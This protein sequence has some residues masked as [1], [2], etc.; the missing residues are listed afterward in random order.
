MTFVT[1]VLGSLLR[2]VVVTAFVLAISRQWS[3]RLNL[4]DA[5]WR[6]LTWAFILAPG[7]VPELLLGY[8]YAPWVIGKPRLAEIVCTLLLGLRLLPVGVIAWQLTPPS[9]LSRSA[10]HVRRMTP[11]D[12]RQMI[13][14]FRCWWVGP[15]RSTIPAAAL[16]GLLAF[17]EFELAALLK[18]VSWTNWLFV[19]QQMGQ[20]FAG[21]VRAATV[22]AVLQI[23]VIG[24]A[25]M[26]L[27]PKYG[28]TASTASHVEFCVPLALPVSSFLSGDR[29]GNAEDTGRASG[30]Q[31]LKHL[32]RWFLCGLISAWL[33][34]ILA[35]AF[36]VIV[37]LSSLTW[38]LPAGIVQLAGQA[39]RWQG[40]L[41][42]L[43]GN[44]AVSVTAACAAWTLAAGVP[45]VIDRGR[46]RGWALLVGIAC[47][48]GLSGSLVLSLGMLT[49]FQRSLSG[50]YDTPVMWVLASILFLLPRAVL[51]RLWLQPADGSA[52]MIAQSLCASNDPSQR[53]AGRALVWRLRDEPRFL[54]VC[55]LAYASY[56]ELT[57]AVL[58]APTG[59][60]SGLVR[61]YNFLHFGR[62]AALSA[63][64]TVLLG[65]PLFF[66][67]VVWGLARKGRV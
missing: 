67:A 17:Q 11:R 33:C 59:L 47:L 7:L 49:L 27:R 57:L 19:N 56:L 24:A 4:V 25:V 62:T 66:A 21:L 43:L 46:R 26:C 35:W 2:A 6:G 38:G 45:P 60:P 39:L 34:M 44:V 64:M 29:V 3:R 14:L 42:E 31:R 54:A 58:L 20:A 65:V 30:T 15:I 16:V 28:N 55:Y 53:R 40:L 10:W 23:A 13:E 18:A 32:T 8:A 41:R 5:R 52:V 61:L 63:E 48:P 9:P 50:L 37:P 22:P 51:L 36:I 12:R 1:A